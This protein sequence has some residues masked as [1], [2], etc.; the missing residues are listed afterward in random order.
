MFVWLQMCHKTSFEP[1]AP[2]AGKAE[3]RKL[4]PHP[5]NKPKGTKKVNHSSQTGAEDDDSGNASRSNST[6]DDDLESVSSQSKHSAPL[7]DCAV[8]TGMC[9]ELIAKNW[10]I[11]N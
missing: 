11:F 7:V 4:T 10:Q 9:F 2:A 3:S 6:E 8:Q 1:A 5:P